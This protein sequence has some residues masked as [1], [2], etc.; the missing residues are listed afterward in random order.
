MAGKGRKVV[1]WYVCLPSPQTMEES[2]CLLSYQTPSTIEPRRKGAAISELNVDSCLRQKKLPST[3]TKKPSSFNPPRSQY[4]V[5]FSLFKIRH[6][7]TL[8]VTELHFTTSISTFNSLHQEW[9]Q[10]VLTQLSLRFSQ[11]LPSPWRAACL[12]PPK[13]IFLLHNRQE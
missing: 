9:L 13:M 3:W 11:L 1:A 7:L 10:V 5:A 2:E 8:L 6:T 12:L 4:K